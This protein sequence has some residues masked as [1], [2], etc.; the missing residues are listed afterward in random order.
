MKAV[1]VVTEATVQDL[2]ERIKA[3]ILEGRFDDVVARKSP[4]DKPFLPSRFF[5]LN[6][7]KSTQSL[8]QI[9]EAEYNAAQS[10]GVPG[11]DRDGRLKREHDEINNIWERICRKLD[12]LCNTHFVPKQVSD[13]ATT[14]HTPFLVFILCSPMPPFRP[15]QMPQPPLLN[16]HSQQQ[17]PLRLCLL[18]KNFLHQMH[19]ICKTQVNFSLLRNAL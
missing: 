4:T 12:A 10:N 6:D 13:I 3:R 17:C 19:P 9:Y 16:R 8:A 5:E 14:P 2:E 18:Q 15:F 7:T 11:D 1:P